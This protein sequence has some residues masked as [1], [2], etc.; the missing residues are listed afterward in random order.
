M[1]LCNAKRNFAVQ[2][3]RLVRLTKWWQVAAIFYAIGIAGLLQDSWPAALP[4]PGVHLH[5]IFGA[6][7]WVAVVWKFCRANLEDSPSSA[8][9]VHA[10]R[11]RLSRQIYLLLY[12]LFGASYIIRMA[13][14]LWNGGSQG[15]THP[16][17]VPAPENLRD[18][19]AFGTVA[20][21]TI[22]A[23]AALRFQALRRTT[24]R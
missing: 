10:L 17:T 1:V 20:L 24:A 21:L 2:S 3:Q 11:R 15:I 22:H 23:L 13:A 18:F 16:A 9:A 8:A 7:L 4:L 14:I 6:F 19:L 12:V 5:A